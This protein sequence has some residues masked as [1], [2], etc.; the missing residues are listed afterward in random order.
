MSLYG[1]LFSGVS[2]LAAQSSAMGAISDNITNVNTVGYKGAQVNFQTLV[3]K[4]TSATEYSPGGVQSKPRGAIDS[5]GLLQSTT[6]TTDLALSGQGMF[7]VNTDPNSAVSG[8][9][10]FAYTRAGSFKVDK[11]GY[12]QNVSGFYVQGWP[13]APTNNNNSAKPTETTIDGNTYMKAYKDSTGQYHYCNQNIINPQEVKS[14]NLKTIGGTADQTTQIKMGANLPSGDTIYN[15]AQTSSSG[16]HQTSALIYDSLGDTHTFNINWMKTNANQWDVQN[17]SNFYSVS[18]TMTSTSQNNTATLKISGSAAGNTTGGV[19]TILNNTPAANSMGFFAG[20]GVITFDTP[21]PAAVTATAL[22]IGT[23]LNISGAS[24]TA[25]NN[26]GDWLVTN[27]L[28]STPAISVQASTGATITT[29]G[30]SSTFATTTFGGAAG[31]IDFGAGATH[32]YN[33]GDFIQ[34]SN[35][36]STIANTGYY[37]VTATTATT[38]TVSPVDYITTGTAPFQ[39]Q[40]GIQP[41]SGAAQMDVL[42]AS[43]NVYGSQAR[44]DFTASSHADIQA[45][46]GKSFSLTVGGNTMNVYFDTTGGIT[47]G[48]NHEIVIN[49]NNT[50]YSSGSDVATLVAQALRNP[51]NWDMAAGNNTALTAT[52]VTAGNTLP[53]FR[54]NGGTVEVV[55]QV[56]GQAVAIN[57]GTTGV[58]TAMGTSITQSQAR[59]WS[60]AIPS[61]DT[62]DGKFTLSAIAAGTS[63]AIKFNGD[64][65][66]QSINVGKMSI[67]WANGAQSQTTVPNGTG[68]D[69]RMSWFVGNTSQADGMTQLGGNYSLAYMSQN[70]AKFGNFTGVSVGSDGVVTAL[71]DNGVRRPVFQ[72]PVAT[73]TNANGMEGLTGNTWIE[74]NVSGT[75]TLR[76]AGEAGSASVNSG[77]LESSTVDIGTEF[78]TMIVTQRAYSAAAKVITTAD[79]MLDELVQIKR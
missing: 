77:S 19:S 12:L 24:G 71:F 64:G 68:A 70:G 46:N 29:N 67:V 16:Y 14:L 73:F 49:L 17:K 47:P 1:A 60:T 3:T 13:L 54:A 45:M 35:N 4:Q 36:A 30:S 8:T 74:T 38:I 53:L 28:Q 55:Q 63:P 25:T 11:Q 7:V 78:T 59:N 2:G 9:G 69:Q 43:G 40:R 42:D 15:P 50:N 33:A 72:I 65:T 21:T 48:A 6:S 31:L 58:N 61:V 52:L 10:R 57:C 27:T 22:P 76:A 39:D 44:L 5:Q 37:K 75:Y 41:P 62:V 18:R 26:N 51:K 66:P 32:T 79:Q 23:V 34:V 20:T 56:G